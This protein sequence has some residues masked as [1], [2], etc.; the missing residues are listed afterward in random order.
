[1]IIKTNTPPSIEKIM[2]DVKSKLESMI[3]NKDT[4]YLLEKVEELKDRRLS[5]LKSNV[6]R[7]VNAV[8]HSKLEHLKSIKLKDDF[9]S[10]YYFKTAEM[11]AKVDEATLDILKCTRVMYERV[12]RD[13]CEKYIIHLRQ[14]VINNEKEV[15]QDSP[16]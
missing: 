1:M 11:F 10:I 13:F 12:S 2:L 6:T 15:L 9:E 4:S 3:V 8:L 7:H 5:I 16:F 14:S